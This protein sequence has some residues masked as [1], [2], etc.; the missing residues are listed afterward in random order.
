M[1]EY[2]KLLAETGLAL[3]DA[4]EALGAGEHHG[5]GQALD[6]ADDLLAE[7]RTRWRSMSHAERGIVS[8]AGGPLRHRSDAARTRL[9]PP[10]GV[11][12]GAP[13]H[14]SEQDVDPAPKVA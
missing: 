3:T 2:L 11:I 9:S 7:L 12:Q 8:R 13:E 14:D 6:R 10:A 1:D 5:A 4:E